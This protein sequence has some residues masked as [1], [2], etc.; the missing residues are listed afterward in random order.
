MLFKCRRV[1]RD[2]RRSQ[3][4]FGEF[5]KFVG[6]GTGQAQSHRPISDGIPAEAIADLID[7]AV[8]RPTRHASP[9]TWAA[10]LVFEAKR[11]FELHSYRRCGCRLCK[12]LRNPGPMGR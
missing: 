7:R 6:N 4:L 5:A 10:R 9:S 2:L 11:E 8:R 12:N 3:V 1:T